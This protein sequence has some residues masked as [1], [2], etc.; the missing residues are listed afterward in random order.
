MWTCKSCGRTFASVRKQHSCVRLSPEIHFKDKPGKLPGI[1]KRLEREMKKLGPVSVQTV[2]SAI[3]F[4]NG[5]VFASVAV[6]RDHLKVEFCLDSVHDHFPVIKVFRYT[7]TKNVH[8]VSLSEPG[9]VNAQLCRWLKR[10]YELA[11]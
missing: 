10:S 4:R 2:K 9:D 8:V 6:R 3:Q 1:Y 11:G 5:A 7:A